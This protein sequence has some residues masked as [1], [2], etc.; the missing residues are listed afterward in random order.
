MKIRN[1]FVSNSSSSSFVCDVCGSQYEGYD[2]QYD[3]VVKYECSNDHI[4]C[5]GFIELDVEGKR[6]VLI[7]DSDNQKDADKAQSASTADIEELWEELWEDGDYIPE[8][9]CP[10]CQFVQI[11]DTDLA[12][13]LME[14]T[15]TV[16][17]HALVDIKRRFGSYK[18]F[19]E[20]IYA[21][22]D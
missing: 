8:E 5:C 19:H 7:K 2:G 20:A 15:K 13:Y 9:S 12:N 11:S 17:T 21:N 18:E 22:R 6:R 14:Q 1:G 10:L 16:R 3:G 4:Y